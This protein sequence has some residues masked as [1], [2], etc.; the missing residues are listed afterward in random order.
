[1][2]AVTVYGSEIFL[3]IHL[4]N[5]PGDAASV[6]VVLELL[7]AVFAIGPARAGELLGAPAGR[8]LIGES[9]SWVERRLGR[10]PKVESSKK[11]QV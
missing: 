2:A 8:G 7:L 3:G 11:P 9:V 6:T 10:G 1:V 5:D 4:L